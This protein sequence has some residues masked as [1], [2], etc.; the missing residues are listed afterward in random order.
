MYNLSI[1][2]TRLRQGIEVGAM[3][4]GVSRHR[5]LGNLLIGTFTGT[6]LTAYIMYLMLFQWF[7]AP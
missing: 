5:L 4:A 2:L 3:A 1:G 7:P 6:L